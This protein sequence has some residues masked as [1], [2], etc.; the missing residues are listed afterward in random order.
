MISYTPLVT[1]LKRK[2]MNIGNLQEL[3]GKK[4]DYLKTVLNQRKYIDM[5]TLDKICTVLNC[6]VSDVIEWKEGE[7]IPVKVE[8]NAN[9][10]WDKL[11]NALLLH[12]LSLADAS[13]FMGKSSSW[14][15]N[16]KTRNSMKKSTLREICAKWNID[17]YSVLLNAL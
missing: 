1:T 9:V 7:Q 5:R 14:I 17:Y 2:R 3:L 11:K 13:V 16:M 8:R 6:K 15:P 12:Q 4:N 10:D